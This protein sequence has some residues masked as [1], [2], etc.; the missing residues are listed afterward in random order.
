MAA[1]PYI[2]DS[3]VLGEKLHEILVSGPLYRKFVYTGQE[4]H[5]I[6][7]PGAGPGSYG[8]LPAQL[9][10]HCGH[11]KCKAETWW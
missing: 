1:F 4:C 11:E 2:K 10:M 5:R 6:T 8:E 7:Y 3:G 9:R